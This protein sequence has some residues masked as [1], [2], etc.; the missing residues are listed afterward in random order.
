MQQIIAQHA[1]TDTI[2]TELHAQNAVLIVTHALLVQFA[3]HASLDT[4]YPMAIVIGNALK[5]CIVMNA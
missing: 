2:W 5:E 3:H 1:T 4:C